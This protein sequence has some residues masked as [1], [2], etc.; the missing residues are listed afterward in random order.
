MKTIYFNL[1]LFG[2]CAVAITAAGQHP[3]AI[4]ERVRTQSEG[5]VLEESLAVVEART[6]AENRSD[7]GLELRLEWS[8]RSSAGMGLRIYLPD[9][10]TTSLLQEQLALAAESEELRVASL[11]WSAL[12]QVYRRFCDYRKFKQQL[13]LYDQELQFLKPHL[14]QADIHVQRN[15]LAVVERAK[16]YGLQV[17]L[18]NSS[19]RMQSA[20]MEIEQELR[21]LLG[22]DADLEQ[23][24]R[25]ARIK[26]PTRL[27]LSGLLLQALQ[28]RPD[29][30]R[31]DLQTQSLS[32]ATLAAQSKEG[33]QFKYIQ[34]SY[35]VDYKTGQDTWSISAAFALPWGNRNPDIAVFQ[36]E[37]A[38][39]QATRALQRIQIQNRLRI[40]LQR[41]EAFCER[42]E[43]RNAALKPFMDQLAL[44][45]KEIE[46]GRLDELRDLMQI[47]ERMLEV[48]LQAAEALCQ[49]ERLIVDLT[50]EIGTMEL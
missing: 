2:W 18:L 5:A 37:Q 44:D 26:L 6:R 48:S 36:Q 27:E 12:M 34:P 42:Y 17:D 46:T 32:A 49:K 21:L 13:S 31:F 14:E 4:K 30:K 9:R 25:T 3:E 1:L 47:R 40:M 16:L 45:L 19:E 22:F 8:E 15:Q 24:S 39:S 50:E 11:E 29:Y 38:L 23:I 33:F 41:Y 20:L 43:K 35:D 10:W 28:N 7:Y